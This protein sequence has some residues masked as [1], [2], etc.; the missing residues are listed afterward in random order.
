M[1]LVGVAVLHSV[2]SF[3]CCCGAALHVPR[4]RASRYCEIMR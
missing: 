2:S 4:S 1:R 3:D